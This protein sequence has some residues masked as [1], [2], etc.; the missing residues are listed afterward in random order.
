MFF[1]TKF[2][3]KDENYI[4]RYGNKNICIS[5]Y[6]FFTCYVFDFSFQ[7][8]HTLYNLDDMLSARHEGISPTLRDDRLREEA[9]ALERKYMHKCDSQVVT[10]LNHFRLVSEIKNSH[11]NACSLYIAEYL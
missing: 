7:M 6:S 9:R 11:D 10:V 8:I 1:D 3:Q 5:K 2:R 4:C